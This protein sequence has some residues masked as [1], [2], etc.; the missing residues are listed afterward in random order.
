[1]NVVSQSYSATEHETRSKPQ[2]HLEAIDVIFSRYRRILYRVAYRVLENHEEAEEAVQNCLLCSHIRC[3]SKSRKLR[4]IDKPNGGLHEGRSTYFFGS[5]VSDA[6]RDCHGRNFRQIKARAGT[7]R[8]V[9]D[10]I[11]RWPC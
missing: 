5:S 10:L 2:E 3:H 8:I 6:H 1:M 4:P 7:E 9:A 11:G